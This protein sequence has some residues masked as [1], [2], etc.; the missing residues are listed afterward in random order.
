MNS[1]PS[2]TKK[3]LTNHEI[4]TLA[5]Y[6]LGGDTQYVDT[7]DIAVKANEIVP[8]RFA[9]RKFPNQINIENVRTFHS[10]A[11]NRR[12]EGILLCAVGASA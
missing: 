8:G 6:L 12:M 3:V 9:W 7:E 2:K 4:V 11:K 5:E 1:A 10:D